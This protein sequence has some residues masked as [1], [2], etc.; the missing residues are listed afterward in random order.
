LGEADIGLRTGKH[1]RLAQGQMWSIVAD[2]PGGSHPVA[3]RQE[4]YEGRESDAGDAANEEDQHTDL[5]TSPYTAIVTASFLIVDRIKHH[6]RN[7]LYSP[8]IRPMRDSSS[9][10]V[11]TLRSVRPADTGSAELRK[12]IK[13]RHAVALYVSS[14]LGSG[15]LVLPGLAA[16]LAGP[17]SLVAWVV[18]S[19][20]SYPF[21]YTFASLSARNPESGGI[22]SF[23]KESFGMPIAVVAGWLFAFWYITGGPAATLIAASYL[24]Y[25]FPMDRLGIF[26]V[27]G[28]VT[29]LAFVVN[30]RGIVFSNKIQ[31]TVVVS[32]IGLLLAAVVLSF[33][34]VD[35][36]H[37]SPFL[38]NGL[39]PVGTAAALIF[40]SFLGYENVSNVAE[41]FEDPKRDFQRSI[42]LS[43]VV[44][45]GLYIAVAV[46]TVGTNA[47]EAGGSVAPFAAI[48]SSML[49]SYGAVGTAVLAV[50]IIFAT[51]NAYTAGMSRVILAVARDGGMPKGMDYVDAKS[52]TPTR[53]LVM[54]SGLSL[55]MLIVYYFLDVNLQTA[56]LIPSAAAILVYVIGSGAGIRLLRERGWKRV[57][58]WISLLLS[59]AVLPFVGVLAVAAVLT[60]LV[61]LV[62]VSMRK[63][64][65]S[66]MS[67]KA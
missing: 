46:V 42:V 2:S 26:I 59:V 56:L 41:E 23:A 12:A 18:L 35:I 27:A 30:Y 1:V 53:G 3:R 5:A 9:K 20:A 58:P 21:A 49:G 66:A 7:G 31:L 64:G 43:V 15:V 17:A 57:L 40:W 47:Y 22:Y 45:S 65:S 37:F 24:A 25:A 44:I 4:R 29:A 19:L 10:D 33:G 48:F 62:Y 38:P 50:V 16:Q 14:V 52:G 63:R 54:L 36:N 8:N 55:C 67:H 32:I 11:V 13:L 51:V 6:Y 60:G 34:R 39:L 61:A 28:C